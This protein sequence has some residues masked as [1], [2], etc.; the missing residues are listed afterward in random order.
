MKKQKKKKNI[1]KKG[2]PPGTNI[3][4]GKEQKRPV[5][6]D[7]YSF[8]PERLDIVKNV[9]YND[10]PMPNEISN[11]WIDLDGVHDADIISNIG[12]KYG[13][14]ALTIEDL[15]NTFQRPKSD[16][17]DNYIYLTIK[18]LKVIHNENGT[19]DI[20]DEQVSL[21]LLE[22]CLIS[23][24]SES[25]DVFDPIR[26][27]LNDPNSRMRN[28]GEDYLLYALLDIIVDNYFEVLEQ[29]NTKCDEI[30]HKLAIS[31][32]RKLIFEIQDLKN[33]LVQMRRFV[34]PIKEAI[35][36]IIRTEHPLIKPETNKYFNDVLDHVNQVFEHLEM[37]KD[38]NITQREIHISN[39]SLKMNQV[40]EALTIVSVIFIPLTFIV[41]V[42]GMNFKYM[43]ELE[44]EN[45]YFYVWFAM[46]FIVI[47]MIVYFKRKKWM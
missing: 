45:G 41:G 9:S 44:H 38:I 23:F 25:G 32:D 2:L 21:V 27:R 24:Q 11:L 14:H 39:L 6:I 15:L 40:M 33:E 13:I 42:Y 1:S 35:L 7:F 34:F 10:L 20:D 28:N 31:T 29:I 19:I 36:K 16:E 8:N 3:Y 22:N 37:L 18:M 43:P 47:G 30:E 12:T 17:F 26:T 5:F 46:I 4:I